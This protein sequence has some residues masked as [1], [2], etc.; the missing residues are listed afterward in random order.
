MRF[1]Y[2]PDPSNSPI[3]FARSPLDQDSITSHQCPH[4]VA[5]EWLPEQNS[6]HIK[7]PSCAWTIPT[8]H[9]T[10]YQ[11]I[12]LS[13]LT[14][15]LFPAHNILTGQ[16]RPGYYPISPLAGVHTSTLDRVLERH[17]RSLEPLHYSL[18]SGV[19][20]CGRCEQ[21]RKARHRRPVRCTLSSSRSPG[22]AD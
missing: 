7:R 9:M 10:V 5:I 15:L 20:S 3:R 21:C 12:T 19:A 8:K 11:R 1:P 2:D 4:R 14:T 16:S 13:P 18:A 6:D 22:A 17:A